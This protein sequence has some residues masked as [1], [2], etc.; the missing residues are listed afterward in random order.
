MAGINT[1]WRASS[2]KTKTHPRTAWLGLL[3]SQRMHSRKNKHS[4][5]FFKFD[6]FF[7]FGPINLKIFGN[8]FF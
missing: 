6:R 7:D 1:G 3:S 4:E 5:S 2:A 8:L